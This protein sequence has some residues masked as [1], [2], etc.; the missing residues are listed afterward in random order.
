MNKR[1]SSHSIL[2]ASIGLAA[3]LLVVSSCKKSRTQP[4]VRSNKKAK[5]AAGTILFENAIN[6]LTTIDQRLDVS[7]D[8]PTPM[9]NSMHT[10]DQQEVKAILI[11]DPEQ[12]GEQYVLLVVPSRNALFEKNG[13]RPGDILRYY[14]QVDQFGKEQYIEI[15]ISE[16]IDDYRLRLHGGLS[17]QVSIPVRAEVWRNFRTELDEVREIMETWKRTGKPALGWEPSPDRNALSQISAS[18]NQSLRKSPPPENWKTSP[19]LVTLEESYRKLPEL[20]NLDKIVFSQYDVRRLQEVIWLRDIASHAIGDALEDLPRAERIFDWVVRNIQLETSKDLGGLQLFPWQAL[21]YG[22]GT[23]DTRNWLFM[24]LCRQQSIQSVTL[25]F[26]TSEKPEELVPWCVAM[27]DQ[28]ELYLFDTELG[29]PIPGPEGRGVATLSQ[30]LANP[31]LLKQLDVPGRPYPIDGKK[32]H[33]VVAFIEA[34]PEYLSKK[35]FL[36][37]KRLSTSGQRLKTWVDAT[38]LAGIIEKSEHISESRIWPIPYKVILRQRHFDENQR[39]AMLLKFRV[40]PQVPPL[41]KGRSMQLKGDNEKTLDA[42]GAI[43]YLMNSRAADR[44]LANSNILPSLRRVMVTAKE[45]ASYWLGLISFEAGRFDPA[46]NYFQVL[47]LDAS[48]NGHWA[49]GASYNLGRTYEAMNQP[50]MA[51]AAYEKDQTSPQR[52]GNLLRAERLRAQLKARQTYESPS[53]EESG[54][55]EE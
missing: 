32:I 6:T 30:V 8:E 22:Q 2:F 42:D 41:W 5:E 33:Q 43:Q 48:E 19:L 55:A 53:P 9:V 12:P 46:I 27:W 45:N 3:M 23:I 37:Q 16:V 18:L 26:S 35:N 13:V 20:E 4:P 54:N 31:E 50:E 21:L 1:L 38:A 52:F 11:D 40:Y 17:G 10:S 15:P 28:G 36:V 44:F 49:A 29:V 51:I 14:L 34:S 47:T 7:L 39:A 24:L 25:A